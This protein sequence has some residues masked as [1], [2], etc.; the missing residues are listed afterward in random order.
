VDGGAAL[1][2][3]LQTFGGGDLDF[4]GAAWLAA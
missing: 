1:L 2:L 4:V 3:T